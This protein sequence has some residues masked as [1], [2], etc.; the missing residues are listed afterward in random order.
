M[1]IADSYAPLL[2]HPVR[3]LQTRPSLRRWK[4]EVVAV[5]DGQAIALRHWAY[6]VQPDLVTVRGEAV[7]QHTGEGV[8]VGRG[9]GEGRPEWISAS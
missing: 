6:G 1:F 5:V 9:G 8:S 2:T 3:L 4:V 7:D